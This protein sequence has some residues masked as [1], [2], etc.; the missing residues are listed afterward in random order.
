M[1][2]TPDFSVSIG[3]QALTNYL[4]SLFAAD[5]SA[6]PQAPPTVSLSHTD[7]AGGE[8]DKF[9]ITFARSGTSAPP[10]SGD[11]VLVK[12][13]YKETGLVDKGK[14][15]V[16]QPSSNID[17]SGGRTIT[18]TA[19]SADMTGKLKEP[20]HEGYEERKVGA[21]VKKVAGRNSLSPVVSKSLANLPVPQADQTHESDMHFLS[22][23]ARDLGANFKVADGKLF[24]LERRGMKT[25]SG[26]SLVAYRPAASDIISA[27]WQGGER[28]SYKSVEAGYHDQAKA[29]RMVE[30]AGS[31]DPKRTLNRTF[32]TKDQAK[33]AAEAELKQGNASKDTMEV[34]MVGNPF[35]QAEDAFEMPPLEVEYQGKW[36]VQKVENNYAKDGYTTSL[37]LERP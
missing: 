7:N 32:A 36:S 30:E 16:D 25:A 9:E 6:P 26:S 28:Q 22:R 21:V 5:L 18:I 14:F 2:S 17:K 15:I 19:T 35:L 20:R 23:I 12:L 1:T 10:K 27:S 29:K 4:H 37:S 33:K 34:E 13:G 11:E 24:F 31:G 8:S 3:G